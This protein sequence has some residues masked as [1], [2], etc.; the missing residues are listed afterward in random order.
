M[1]LLA[2][3]AE[4]MLALLTGHM[5]APSVL[6][7]GYLALWA[8]LCEDHF[9]DLAPKAVL[10]LQN[11]RSLGLDSLEERVILGLSPLKRA[12]GTRVRVCTLAH[13]DDAEK[14]TAG[15][16]TIPD[17]ICPAHV[18]F[19]EQILEVRLLVLFQDW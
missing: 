7:N 1:I 18:L 8:S 4:L 9:I 15:L 12:H 5:H 2:H 13:L 10:L 17:I 11:P 6:S 16:R 19:E 3:P 14:P